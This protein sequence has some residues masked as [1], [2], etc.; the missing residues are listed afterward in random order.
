M[1][2]IV[3]QNETYQ[4]SETTE[5]GWSMQGNA[6]KDANGSLSMTF[7]V[8]KS[9][10]EDSGGSDSNIGNCNYIKYSG[11]DRISLNYDVDEANRDKFA[12]YIDT[13]IDSVLAHFSE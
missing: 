11:S 5:D 9:S 6:S 2:E 10:T 4:I 12:T 3:K 1:V 13:V 8:S 7:Q